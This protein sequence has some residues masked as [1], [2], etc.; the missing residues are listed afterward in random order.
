VVAD[1]SVFMHHC[2]LINFYHY[3]IP[4]ASHSNLEPGH[5]WFGRH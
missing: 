1:D 4:D 2:K 3:S 5:F